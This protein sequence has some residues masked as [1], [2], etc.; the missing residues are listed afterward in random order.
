[1]VA[2]ESK[3]KQQFPLLAGSGGV[4]ECSLCGVRVEVC[5][6]VRPKGWLVC[7]CVCVCVGG[8]P[9]ILFLLLTHCFYTPGSSK[10]A[11]GVFGLFLSFGSSVCSN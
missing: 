10:L 11:A 3:N 2:G 7:V 5:P 9:S 4:S 8:M 6:G 1:M